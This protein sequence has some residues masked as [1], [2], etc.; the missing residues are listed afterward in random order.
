[1]RRVWT[2]LR[3]RQGEDGEE[4]VGRLGSLA[5]VFRHNPKAGEYRVI[6]RGE[7]K[8]PRWEKEPDAHLLIGDRKENQE[9]ARHQGRKQPSQCRSCGAAGFW[10]KTDRDKNILLNE[11]P[12][13]VDYFNEF[14][15]WP[16]IDREAPTFQ[17]I[18]R[19]LPKG[20][21]EAHFATCPNAHQHRA[22]RRARAIH[23][24]ALREMGDERDPDDVP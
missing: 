19:Q 13:L 23:Q 15:P 17:E 8:R 1:M 24:D 4:F 2:G 14:G 10:V 7:G 21:V 16:I 11:S 18:K 6:D 20:T 12:Q 22:D 3:R 5:V 9:M